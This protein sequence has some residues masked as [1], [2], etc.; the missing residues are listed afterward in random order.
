MWSYNP[1]DPWVVHEFYRTTHENLWWILLK[2]RHEWPVEDE[3]IGLDV[4]TPPLEDWLALAEKI[5]GLAPLP[6][7]PR[8]PLL[9]LMLVEAPYMAL[10]NKKKDTRGGLHSRAKLNRKLKVSNDELSP[11][12]VQLDK[13]QAAQDKEFEKLK[14]ELEQAKKEITELCKLSAELKAERVDWR[15]FEEEVCQAKLMAN[16]KP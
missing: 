5:D 9:D 7:E 10:E 3:D 8:S 1:S 2:L 6:E 13:K 11:V 12:N 16:G 4:E 14:A 15:F